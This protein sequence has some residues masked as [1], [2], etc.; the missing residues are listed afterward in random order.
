MVSDYYKTLGV[1]RTA[2]QDEIKAAFR[3]QAMQWHPDRNPQ[4]SQDQ[5][6][7]RFVEVVQ[8]RDILSS[9][10][11]RAE[12]DRQL[13]AKRDF[14]VKRGRGW[15]PSPPPPPSPEYERAERESAERAEHFASDY[16][17]FVAWLR[18][19]AEAVSAHVKE[20]KKEYSTAAGA[21]TGAVVGGVLLGAVFPPAAIVGARLGAHLGEQA[22]KEKRPET[23]AERRRREKEEREGG[24]FC[25]G[26]LIL[27]A[28]VV[29]VLFI[30]ANQ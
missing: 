9:P 18:G 11:T 5:A 13:G 12:H 24:R 17:L 3:R 29:G 7:R 6:H 22:A 8:A 25:C 14:S 16:D 19:A 30:M 28:V 26:C 21:A 15:A 23:E 20:N 2:S 1:A 10:A 27:A 4:A